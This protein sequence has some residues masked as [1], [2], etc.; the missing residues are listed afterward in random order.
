MGGFEEESLEQPRFADHGVSEE[1]LFRREWDVAV[2]GGGVIGMWSALYLARN[3]AR[4]VLVDGGSGSGCCSQGSA[5]LLVPS[6]CKPLPGPGRITEG[7]CGLLQ[8]P[9][10]TLSLSPGLDP[11]LW[12]WLA[13]F[14]LSC[15]RSCFEAG[16][17][18]LLEMGWRSLELMETELSGQEGMVP[19]GEGVLYPY[20]S[21]RAWIGA[22]REARSKRAPGLRPRV[23]SAGEAREAEPE[24]DPAVLGAVLQE[25]DRSVE[26]ERLVNLLHKALQREGVSRLPHTR[27]YALDSGSS[28][29]VGRIRTTRGTLRAKQVLLATGSGTRGLLR[30]MGGWLPIRSGTGWS[31][32]FGEAE[33][34]PERPMLLEEARVGIAPWYGGFRITGG[35]ELTSRGTE[36]RRSRL[37]RVLRLARAYLPGLDYSGRPLVR[38]GDRPLTPDGLPVLGPMPGSGNL[39]VAA[40]HANLGLTLGAASGEMVAGAM[41][42]SGKAIGEALAPDRFL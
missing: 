9:G 16:A 13:R 32:S 21:R 33:R 41:D 40:G 42:G 35:L 24:L 3:G 38:Q 5:G 29:S 30:S 34:Q 28:G 25:R 22:V 18:V 36:I 8:M 14:A 26:P 19:A 31:V 23:L 12:C 4:V 10:S 6:R 2:A 11:D 1:E 39:W 20:Y 17:R 37:Q 27:V 15:R 7:L